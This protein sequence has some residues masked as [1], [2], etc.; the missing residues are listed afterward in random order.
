M[1]E[2]LENHSK[3]IEDVKKD[4]TGLKWNY[5]HHEQ[6]NLIAEWH[7]CRGEPEDRKIEK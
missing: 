5:N 4:Q 1:D 7:E 6:G 2:K 3:E